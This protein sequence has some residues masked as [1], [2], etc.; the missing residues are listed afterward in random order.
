MGTKISSKVRILFFFFFYIKK[1]K[2]LSPDILSHCCCPLDMD[3]SFLCTMEQKAV[4][5]CL[6]GWGPPE[7]Q[8]HGGGFCVKP[9]NGGRALRGITAARQGRR[10]RRSPCGRTCSWLVQASPQSPVTACR[11]LG[12]CYVRHLAMP[13]HL[14]REAQELIVLQ[15]F[16]CML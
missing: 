3:L 11:A 1:N 6:T 8:E 9:L 2:N 12:C 4:Y 16:P 14:F 10:R 5:V 7:S 13:N 15:L